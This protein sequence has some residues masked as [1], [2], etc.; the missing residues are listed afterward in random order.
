MPNARIMIM[1]DDEDIV[2]YLKVFLLDKGYEI[3]GLAASGEDAIEVA[4]TCRPDLLIAD[5]QLEGKMDGIE[6]SSAIREM[7]H[8]PILFL[9]A[10]SHQHLFDRAKITRPFA[11]LLKP[12]EPRELELTI[13]MAFYQH[14]LETQ[15]RLRE[16]HL[17]E[18]QEIGN[19]GSWDWNITKGTLAWT[20][21]IFRI[22]GQSPQSFDATYEAFI[23]TIHPD[24]LELVKK[25][26]NEALETGKQYEIEHRIVLPAGEEKVVRERGAVEFDRTNTAIRMQGDSPG[27]NRST[28]SGETDRAHGLL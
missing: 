11:Y 28:Y 24:D 3:A 18:A 10:H 16:Q 7:L 25:A 9:T 22:F 20:D 4:K 26:V 5:I 17:N 1:E 21:Q 2:E 6:A 13:E 27:C 14:E 12:V 23:E 15:L 8:I 19:I